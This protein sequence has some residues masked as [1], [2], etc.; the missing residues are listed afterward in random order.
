MPFLPPNQQCQSTESNYRIRIREKTLEFSSTV[1]PAPSPYLLVMYWDSIPA[2]GHPSQHQSSPVLS[3]LT[4]VTNAVTTRPNRH[5]STAPVPNYR[6]TGSTSK[7]Q[8]RNTCAISLQRFPSGTSEG[9]KPEEE[10]SDQ[11][12]PGK[13]RS[14]WSWRRA[15][16]LCVF[17]T[18]KYLRQVFFRPDVLSVV[19][20]AA[21]L[22]G[23]VS[24]VINTAISQ[25]FQVINAV[26]FV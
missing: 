1:L 3:N 10:P 21:S 26:C 18:G 17:K 4:E 12:S 22:M 16:F 9:R 15:V 2:N 8:P 5:N 24:R 25:L 11:D 20:T 7:N 6:Q 23:V 13:L 19:K 14:K